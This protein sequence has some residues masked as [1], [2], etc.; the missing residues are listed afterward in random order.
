MTGVPQIMGSETVSK[1]GRGGREAK[2][3]KSIKD[4]ETVLNVVVLGDTVDGKRLD[5]T[6]QQTDGTLRD[7]NSGL[8]QSK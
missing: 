3:T 2:L 4:W 8:W 1:G 6:E 7:A 5:G